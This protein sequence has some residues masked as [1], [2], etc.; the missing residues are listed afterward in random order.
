MAAY[1]LTGVEKRLAMTYSKCKN[2]QIKTLEQRIKS[3]I[4]LNTL[5]PLLGN[6]SIHKAWQ[7]QVMKGIL[8]PLCDLV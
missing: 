3:F 8:C 4:S 1:P 6:S 2:K 5:A 7:C